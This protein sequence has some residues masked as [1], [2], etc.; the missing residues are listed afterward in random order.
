[1]PLYAEAFHDQLLSVLV[2]V[3]NPICPLFCMAQLNTI[4]IQ[5][6]VVFLC[7]NVSSLSAVTVF[8]S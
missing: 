7:E 2:T 5:F 1:M 3:L 4:S 8:M 6:S